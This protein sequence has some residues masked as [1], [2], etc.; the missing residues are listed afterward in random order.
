M[1]R[2]EGKRLREIRWEEKEPG[3]CYPEGTNGEIGRRKMEVFHVIKEVHFPMGIKI[4]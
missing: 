4:E 1:K 2:R 3:G